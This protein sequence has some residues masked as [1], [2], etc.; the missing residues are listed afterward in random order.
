MTLQ[1]YFVFSVVGP[2]HAFCVFSF[3]L[4]NGQYCCSLYK[5]L[6]DYIPILV[7]TVHTSLSKIILFYILYILANSGVDT[8]TA[9]LAAC[10]YPSQFVVGIY[11]LL[12]PYV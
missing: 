12:N 7:Y 4:W 6:Y 10:V 9:N 8:L 3:L 2:L 1:Q 11:I 5:I